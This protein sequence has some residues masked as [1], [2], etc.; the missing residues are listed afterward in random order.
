MSK[1]ESDLVDEPK[2]HFYI[3]SDEKLFF[4]IVLKKYDAN[5]RDMMKKGILKEDNKKKVLARLAKYVKDNIIMGVP[6]GDIK[7]S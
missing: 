7:D 4:V 2:G 6:H 1:K 3:E 5:L